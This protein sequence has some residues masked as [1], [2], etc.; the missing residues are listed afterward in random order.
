[1][2]VNVPGAGKM[3]IMGGTKAGMKDK[4]TIGVKSQKLYNNSSLN[5]KK[6]TT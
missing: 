5:L 1:M 3:T 4:I 6:T 2:S